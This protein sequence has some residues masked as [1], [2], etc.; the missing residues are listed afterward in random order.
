MVFSASKIA[1]FT[2]IFLVSLVY[3]LQTPRGQQQSRIA[4]EIYKSSKIY[5]F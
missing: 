1:C 3:S 5:R 4:Y 2:I